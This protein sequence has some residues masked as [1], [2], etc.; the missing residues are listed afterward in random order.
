MKNTRFDEKLSALH[1]TNREKEISLRLMRGNPRKMI[2]DELSFSCHTL[3]IHLSRIRRKLSVF[4]TLQAALV[5]SEMAR[6]S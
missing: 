6:S 1:F 2:A 4:S 3:D 5:L